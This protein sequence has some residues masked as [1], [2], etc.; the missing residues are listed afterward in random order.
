MSKVDESLHEQEEN[1]ADLGNFYPTHHV[2]VAFDSA[3]QAGDALETAK[4]AGFD[5][6]RQISSSEMASAARHGLET[7]GVLAA[8]GSSLKMVELHKTLADEGCHF[9]LVKA[10]SDEDTERLMSQIRRKPFRMAQ[11]YR[12]LVIEMLE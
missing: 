10:P 1:G 6:L 9:V 7:A 4:S 2:L 12:R 8:L 3:A 11:K 5:E